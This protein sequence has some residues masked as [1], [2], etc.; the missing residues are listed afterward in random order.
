MNRPQSRAR[1]AFLGLAKF[2]LALAALT[3]LSAGTPLGHGSP[4]AL[5]FC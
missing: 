5:G 3:F 1:R 4:W 2:L